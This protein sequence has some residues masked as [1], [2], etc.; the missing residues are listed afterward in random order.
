MKILNSLTPMP[1]QD[2][3]DS[4]FGA[5]IELA[6]ETAVLPAVLYIVLF[7]ALSYGLLKFRD[8]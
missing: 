8:L 6:P 4:A 1:G 2:L 3:L 5:T 7:S